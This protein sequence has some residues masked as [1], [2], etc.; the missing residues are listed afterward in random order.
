MFDLEEIYQLGKYISYI[1]GD[2]TK[3]STDLISTD[4][5]YRYLVT[6]H[7]P[8]VRMASGY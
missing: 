2:L 8:L 5:P 4:N 3:Q 7:V 1:C 6:A